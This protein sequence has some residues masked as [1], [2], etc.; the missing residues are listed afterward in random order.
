MAGESDIGYWGTGRAELDKRESDLVS[1]LIYVSQRARALGEDG[2]RGAWVLAN[3]IRRAL[4][5][6]DFTIPKVAP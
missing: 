5:T 6:G 2:N 4:M 3:E 1:Y